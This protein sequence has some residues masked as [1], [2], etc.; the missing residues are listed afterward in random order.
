MSLNP[1]KTKS[2]TLIELLVVIAIIA[3][4]VVIIAIPTRS[5]IRNARIA[6]TLQYEASLHKN[7]GADIVGW[8]Q[9]DE[10]SGSIAKDISGKNNHGTIYGSTPEGN[11]WVDGVPG[12]GGKALSFNGSSDYVSLQYS[13][14]PSI[15]DWTLCLWINVPS[16]APNQ[17]SIIYSQSGNNGDN[18]ILYSDTT[19][20]TANRQIRLWME[21]PIEILVGPDI[22]GRGW[23]HLTLVRNENNY[24]LYIDGNEN[25]SGSNNKNIGDNSNRRLF[26]GSWG[27]IE[28]RYFKGIGDDVR[29]YN[30][31][32]TAEEIQEIYLSTKDKYLAENNNDKD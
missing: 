16:D 25:K 2:F 10:G 4:L 23:I 20:G 9:F 3:L 11:R 31:A 18:F 24:I 19:F 14:L 7:L 12:K 22:R 29:I 32:L 30:R 28:E 15:E 27:S 1:K 13:I 26:S 17:N 21:S 5:V 6:T 8:W